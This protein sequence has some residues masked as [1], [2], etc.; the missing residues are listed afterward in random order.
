MSTDFEGA[1]DTN[2]SAE[3]FKPL[4]VDVTDETIE[5]LAEVSY[6]YGFVFTMNRGR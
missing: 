6:M 3:L 1:F 4:F 5:S 2:H